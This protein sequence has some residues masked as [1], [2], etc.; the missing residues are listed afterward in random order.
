MNDLGS[1]YLIVDKTGIK[2]GSS[3]DSNVNSRVKSVCRNRGTGTCIIK[4]IRS[5][6]SN[7]FFAE[8]WIRHKATITLGLPISI[9][10]WH[11]FNDI[12]KLTEDLVNKL[13]DII[14]SYKE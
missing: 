3:K 2:I 13:I 6:I 5:G 10:E 11:N 7:Y 14:K 12:E 4:Y 8:E 9:N 1:I